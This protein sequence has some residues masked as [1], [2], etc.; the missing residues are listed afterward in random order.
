MSIR[1]IR[2]SSILQRNTKVYGPNN[3][4]TD[5]SSCWNSEGNTETSHWF[6]LDFG[7]LVRPMSLGLQFQAGFCAQEGK[8]EYRLNEN[9]DW[10]VW[11]DQVEWEDEHEMQTLDLDGLPPC[12]ALR[13]VMEECTDFY[14]RVILYQVQ[15][16]GHEN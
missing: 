6:R 3:A 4:L 5:D 2:A 8:V 1:F 12:T 9:D 11:N 10:K 16:F 13:I 14:G 15:V 7:R